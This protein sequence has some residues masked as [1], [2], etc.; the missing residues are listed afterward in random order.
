MPSAM[1]NASSLIK[2]NS[3]GLT[4]LDSANNLDLPPGVPIPAGLL[5]NNFIPVQGSL[6]QRMN[7][8]V[9]SDAVF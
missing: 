7:V 4:K 6:L 2:N 9:S 5:D 3:N 1:S 8:G